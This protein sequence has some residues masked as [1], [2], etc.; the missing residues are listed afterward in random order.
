[1]FGIVSTKPSSVHQFG[2]NGKIIIIDEIH[3]YDLYT[4]TLINK[5]VERLRELNCTVIIL[6]ATL[7]EKRRRELLDLGPSQTIGS[8]YPLISGRNHSFI[9]RACEPP[10]P[11]SIRLRA[12]SGPVPVEEVL[13]HA[14]TGECVLWIRNTVNDAQDT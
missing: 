7:T 14:G 3:S 6:S 1:P 9:E 5:L 8:T 4:G 13:A 10:P 11:K 12:L 2:F